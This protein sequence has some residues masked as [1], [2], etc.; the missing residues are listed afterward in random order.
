MNNVV[1]VLLLVCGGLAISDV[2][3]MMAKGQI[4][5]GVSLAYPET[6]KSIYNDYKEVA[7]DETRGKLVRLRFKIITKFSDLF[8]KIFNEMEESI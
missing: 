4:I 6:G 5:S 2:S 3:D 7:D 8:T 1:K